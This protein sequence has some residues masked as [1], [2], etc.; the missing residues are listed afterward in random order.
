MHDSPLFG[1]A[2]VSH[3]VFLEIPAIVDRILRGDKPADL[4]AQAP[5]K[6]ETAVNLKTAKALGRTVPPGLQVAF[7]EKR[8]FNKSNSMSTRPRSFRQ[9]A[10][11]RQH[12][13]AP[14]AGGLGNRIADLE[15]R[16]GPAAVVP[17]RPV[18]R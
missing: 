11:M 3:V 2:D 18:F 6:F 14:L 10:L 7:G 4:P 9:G 17:D 16:H 12:D 1:R 15:H 13:L 8:T 5:T